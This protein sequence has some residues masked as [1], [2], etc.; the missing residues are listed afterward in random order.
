MLLER[1]EDVG[2]TSAAYAA[3]YAPTHEGRVRMHRSVRTSPADVTVNVY[4]VTS[5]L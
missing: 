4:G 5:A 1:R 2:E 3:E